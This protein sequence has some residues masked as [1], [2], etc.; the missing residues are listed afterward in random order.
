MMSQL[1]KFCRWNEPEIFFTP[2]K[3][4]LKWKFPD[5]QYSLDFSHAPKKVVVSNTDPPLER[6]EFVFETY[7]VYCSVVIRSQWWLWVNSLK[8]VCCSS[9]SYDFE[10]EFHYWA[11]ISLLYSA[12][13][14]NWAFI[15]INSFHPPLQL[16][17]QTCQNSWASQ[18]RVELRLTS[19]RR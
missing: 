3:L 13:V 11:W 14:N 4:F 16:K 12:V 19:L 9:P 15:R 1:T 17:G 7:T 5:L 2:R 10:L 6:C 8:A 18:A